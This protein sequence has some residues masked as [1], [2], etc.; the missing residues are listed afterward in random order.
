MTATARMALLDMRTVAPYRY[1]G[2][3]LLVLYSALFLNRPAVLVPALATLVAV[4]IANYPFNVGDKARLG[5]LYAVMPLTRRA[6][7]T[8]HYVWAVATYLTA[9]AIGTVVALV[10]AHVQSEAFGA[11]TVGTDLALSWAA[12]AVVVAIQFPLFIRYGY[13]RTSAI[14]TGLPLAAILGIVYR[15]HVSPASIQSW[16]PLIA[17]AATAVIVASAM[18]ALRGYRT[19]F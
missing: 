17:V 13:T 2:L 5:T 7:V 4:S 6:V 11:G 3:A 12:F 1:Q 14:A 8:G 15:L 19:A 18:I 9:T 16:L 10:S